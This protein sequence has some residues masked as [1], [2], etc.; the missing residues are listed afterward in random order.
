MLRLVEDKPAKPKRVYAGKPIMC[1]PCNNMDLMELH[2][3]TF[4]GGRITKGKASSWMCPY[5]RAIVW[6]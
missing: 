4:K 3:P 2:R 6:P 1:K 5:C